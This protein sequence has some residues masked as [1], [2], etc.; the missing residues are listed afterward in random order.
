MEGGKS[1]V[2]RKF[3]FVLSDFHQGKARCFKLQGPTI[4][5]HGTD[6]STE[7]K[8]P[9]QTWKKLPP[10]LTQFSPC[11]FHIIMNQP[12]AR[13]CSRK[14][15]VCWTWQKCK[16]IKKILFFYRHQANKVCSNPKTS[17]A[18]KK[19]STFQGW[20]LKNTANNKVKKKTKKNG[21]TTFQQQ[22]LAGKIHQMWRK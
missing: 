22:E 19:S 15:N 18:G 13:S 9:R 2:C 5:P 8:T 17:L 16:I 4:K 6:C 10:H 14:V 21:N 12:S 7:P 1:Q 11:T 3:L 20:L